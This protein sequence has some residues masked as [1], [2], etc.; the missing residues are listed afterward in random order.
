MAAPAIDQEH[1]VVVRVEADAGPAHVIGDQEVDALGVELGARV[2]GDIVRLR[3]EADD[4][5]AR[6][7]R[8]HLGQDVG[9]GRQFQREITLALDLDLRRAAHAI[10]GDGRRLD[11]DRR[12]EQVMQ[13]GLAHLLRRLHRHERGRGG[14]CERSRPGH[15]RDLGT[16]AQRGGREVVPHLAGRA[17]RDVAHGID[18][19]AR[20]TG[21]DDEFLAPEVLHRRER[22][23][24]RGDDRV[25]LG[26]ATA[27]AQAGCERAAVRLHHGHAACAQRG[28]VG[29]DRRVFPHPAVHRRCDQDGTARGQQ[30]RGEE[31]VGKAVRRFRDEIRGGRRNDDRRRPLGKGDVLDGVL[32]LR[33]E[34]VGQHG[35][36]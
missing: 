15:E 7:D 24:Q 23:C 30:Q 34:Q 16:A 11:H 22:R 36:A 20:G 18:R 14:R 17:V 1:L 25:G 27:P 28:D 4:E 31:V 9:I 3:G 19:L 8:S 21:G 32:T 5:R 12:A 6:T 33:I 2:G 35:A 26:Q 13:H 29:G 10:V